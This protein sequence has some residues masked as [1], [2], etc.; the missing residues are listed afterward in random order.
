MINAFFIDG[1][2]IFDI[3]FKKEDSKR[4]MRTGKEMSHIFSGQLLT[5]YY[6]VSKLDIYLITE[7]NI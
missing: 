4:M 5:C 6:K 2:P 1:E 3:F 7:K